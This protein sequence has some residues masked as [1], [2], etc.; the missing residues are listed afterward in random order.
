MS[1]FTRSKG[2]EAEKKGFLGQLSLRTKVIVVAVIVFLVLLVL[3]IPGDRSVLIT[4]QETVTVAQ[5]AYDTAFPVVGPIME[6]VKTFI[7]EAG[8]D[9]SDNR[10]YTGLTSALSTFNRNNSKPA[11]KFQGVMTFY[12]NVHSLLEGEA[13]VPELDTDEFQTL[14]ADMDTKLSVALVALNA[15]NTAIDDYNGYHRWISANIAGAL[16][17]LPGGYSDPLPDNSSL[18]VVQLNP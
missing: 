14:V 4:R 2:Q 7:D 15:L 12:N 3:S 17:G 9:L 1:T 5:T 8:I 18:I 10:L 16:Y 13:A 11:S 6:S